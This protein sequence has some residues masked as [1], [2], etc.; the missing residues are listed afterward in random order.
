[1]RILTN[2]GTGEG[3]E[4]KS[5]ARGAAWNSTQGPSNSKSA[6]QYLKECV[7]TALDKGSLFLILPQASWTHTT[8]VE[9][10]NNKRN[11]KYHTVGSITQPAPCMAESKTER[12]SGWVIFPR[13]V[14]GPVGVLLQTWGPRIK[15]GPLYSSL[16][17]NLT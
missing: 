7:K 11:S 12:H 16:F 10:F 6:H 1:M 3:G 13:L 15:H 5:T 4:Q 9:F 2:T 17:S 14:R 8:S